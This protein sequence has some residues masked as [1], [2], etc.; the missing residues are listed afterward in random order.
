MP[1]EPEA[2]A[3]PTGGATR[4]D[5]DAIGANRN[6]REVI[7]KILGGKVLEVIDENRPR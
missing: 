6:G 4:D 1:D 3:D 5:A 2:D 7:E